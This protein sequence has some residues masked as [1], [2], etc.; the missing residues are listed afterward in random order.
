MISKSAKLSS[1]VFILLAI[2]LILVACYSFGLFS[3]SAPLKKVSA[4]NA[5]LIKVLFDLDEEPL[6]NLLALYKKEFGPSAARYARDTYIKW[7]AG[8][9]RPNKQTFARFFVYLPKV[10]SFDLKCEV[11]RELREAYCAKDNY[12]LTVYTDDWKQTLAPLVKEIITKANNAQLPKALEERL[13]WL[14]DKDMEVA[15]ALLTY[16]QTR[17]SLNSLSFLEQEFSNIDQLLAKTQSRSKVTHVLKFPLG[18]ITLKIKR[19]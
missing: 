4:Q 6:N 19:R 8:E 3:R 2:A 1:M 9:V 12:E 13:R 5:E 14:A 15:R 7:K 10:M 18:R 17:E 16:S 11:L